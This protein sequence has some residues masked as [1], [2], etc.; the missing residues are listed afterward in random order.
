MR[1]VTFLLLAV[2]I[3]GATAFVGWWTV[4]V[5]GGAWGLLA[6][7]RGRGRGEALLAAASAAFAWAVL[8]AVDAA[9]GQLGGLG[10]TFGAIAGLPPAVFFALTL[11]FPA[12]LAWSAAALAGSVWPRRDRRPRYYVRPSEAVASDR[13][14][15]GD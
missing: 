1:V 14:P 15:V 12:L 3:A 2:A 4:A 8:L 7:W 6:G 9:G 5:V 10:R 13:V 11:A